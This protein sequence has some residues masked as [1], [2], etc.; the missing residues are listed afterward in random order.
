M[1]RLI[2]SLDSHSIS[3]N[4]SLQTEIW[5]WSDKIWK[6]DTRK[7]HLPFRS[8]FYFDFYIEEYNTWIIRS[9]LIFTFYTCADSTPHLVFERGLGKTPLTKDFLLHLTE[10][11]FWNLILLLTLKYLLSKI[12]NHTCLLKLLLN[13]H[14]Y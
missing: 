14:S 2:F 5:R 12:K 3:K 4:I 7:N 13:A 6:H 10:I 9:T 8:T 11:I 1:Q